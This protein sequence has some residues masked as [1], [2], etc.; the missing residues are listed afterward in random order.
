MLYYPNLIAHSEMERLE[1]VWSALA[2]RITFWLNRQTQLT[3]TLRLCLSY[4][5]TLH[6]INERTWVISRRSVQD[7]EW[8]RALNLS[9][10]YTS[11][12]FIFQLSNLR[13]ENLPCDLLF[14]AGRTVATWNLRNGTAL[15]VVRDKASRHASFFSVERRL[16]QVRAIKT[17]DQIGNQLTR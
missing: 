16:A 17:N 11:L 13:P 9:A 10:A 2:S 7:V 1:K 3:G 8:P 15:I 12:P 4:L 14:S 5:N 6:P